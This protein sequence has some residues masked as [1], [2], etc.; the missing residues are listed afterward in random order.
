MKE[1]GAKS[2]VSAEA[3]DFLDCSTDL[4]HTRHGDFVG[5]TNF[6]SRI[7]GGARGSKI[8]RRHGAVLRQKP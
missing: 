5:L 8:L 3:I 1:V 7:S 2:P 6:R 4:S